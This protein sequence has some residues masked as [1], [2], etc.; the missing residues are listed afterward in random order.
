MNTA[1]IGLGSNIDPKENILKAKEA[2]AKA[3][4]VVAQSAFRQTNPVGYLPQASY[5]NGAVLIQTSL[6]QE[7][8]KASLKK[9]ERQLGRRKDF[10]KYGPR[11]I[12]LDILIWNNRIVDRDF[13]TREFIR[14]SVLELI[15]DL[16]Y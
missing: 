15:P 6:K 10:S 4:I 14:E 12:D 5:I 13:Y 8:L 16:E 2:L 7:E 1:V 11:S 3:Y 9:I